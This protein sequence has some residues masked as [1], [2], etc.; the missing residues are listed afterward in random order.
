MNPL[1]NLL[2][3]RYSAAAGGRMLLVCCTTSD[4]L[5]SWLPDDLPDPIEYTDYHFCSKVK[6]KHVTVEP[7]PPYAMG[8]FTRQPPFTRGDNWSIEE[9][10]SLFLED[11]IIK[12]EVSKGKIISSPYNKQYFPT[13]YNNEIINLVNDDATDKWLLQRR[14]EIFYLINGATFNKVRYTPKFTCKANNV[15]PNDFNDGPQIVFPIEDLDKEVHKDYFE[16][17]EKFKPNKGINITLSDYFTWDPNRIWDTVE[18]MVGELN[19]EWATPAILH[20]RK[21]WL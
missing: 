10:T 11:E 14:K 4:K 16:G 2:F 3:F 8:W 18:P 6:V 20:W 15:N 21:Y 17:N 1:D 5:T 7:Q 9:A 13:W 12:K 19:R